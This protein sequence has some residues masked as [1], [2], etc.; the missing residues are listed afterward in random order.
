MGKRDIHPNEGEDAW[1]S[2]KKH[3]QDLKITFSL[4]DLALPRSLIFWGQG[5]KGKPCSNRIVLGSLEKELPNL[6]HRSGFTFSN[7]VVCVKLVSI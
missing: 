1:E 2:K 4:Y 3:S 5:W 6:I 7:I